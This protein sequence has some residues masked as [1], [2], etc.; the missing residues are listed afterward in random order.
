MNS[1]LIEG[2]FMPLPQPFLWHCECSSVAMLRHWYFMSSVS[3][4]SCQLP[5]ACICNL[6]VEGCFF[7]VCVCGFCFVV[8]FLVFF[9]FF[10]LFLFVT[11]TH[12]FVAHLWPLVRLSGALKMCLE[13]SCVCLGAVF[14][15]RFFSSACSKANVQLHKVMVFLVTH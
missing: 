12:I 4:G 13:G 6:G 10:C 5:H 3:I 15:P 9:L 2:E 1:D 11:Y 14:L 7:V 8:F